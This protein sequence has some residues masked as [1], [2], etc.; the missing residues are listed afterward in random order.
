M[1]LSSTEGTTEAI[2][3]PEPELTPEEMI[4]RAVAL[5]EK[6]LE[7]QAETE[8][9]TYY[10]EEMHEEFLRSGFTSQELRH[11]VRYLQK[12]IRAGRRNVGAL[13]LSNLLQLDLFEEDL[14]ISRVRLHAPSVSVAQS[15]D[16]LGNPSS[17]LSTAD[18][19]TLR[20]EA[21][22]ALQ[23]FRQ[24]VFPRKSRRGERRGIVG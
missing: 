20:R 17:P 14:N 7:Q 9:R 2:A 24:L 5:R 3:P 21:L 11:V 4:G 18:Q 10:A 15:S 19:E 8:E 13:K 16:P 23:R 12:E 1:A 22:I 6:L